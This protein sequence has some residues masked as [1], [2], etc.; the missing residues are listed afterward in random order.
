MAIK[1]KS[2]IM[3]NIRKSYRAVGGK[4]YETWEI[5]FGTDD[6]GKKIR[7][8][9]PS[10]SEARRYVENY[11]RSLD[12]G[13]CVMT[14]LKPR[15]V[16]DA[17]EALD[18][19]AEAG[20]RDV[21]LR[22]CARELIV[23]ETAARKCAASGMTLGP[24]YMEYVK[25]IPE[26][27]EMQR[28]CVRGRIGR[29]ADALGHEYRLA[30]VTAKGVADYVD[31][32]GVA[33][34]TRNNARSYIKTFLS[35]C[36]ADERRYI[37]ENPCAGMKP[38]KEPYKEPVFISAADMEKLAR[39]VEANHPTAIPF[40]VLSYW[41]GIR[42]AEIERLAD[43]PEDIRLEEETIRLSKVKGWTSGR[44]PRI[45]HIEPNALAWMKRHDVRRQLPGRAVVTMR[46]TLYRAAADAG[47]NLGR[48]MGRHSYITH[49]AAKTG[50]AKMVE[51]MAGTSGGMRAKNYDGLST[52]TEG[53]A[54]F[55]IM[56]SPPD[57]ARVRPSL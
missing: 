36:A 15:D 5:Y 39:E 48:N 49:L 44:R 47:V 22:R 13:G 29:W 17:R 56:P 19:L 45:T 32:L 10:L 2:D 41:C 16:L 18:I 43:K 27:C 28:K 20:L 24:A 7:T 3:R 12:T 31:A 30:D 50:D 34:K 14:A 38:E 26:E 35:W 37:A 25:S 57:S 4:A 55:S 53:Q 9:K 52:K 42:T 23:R 21:T 11:F 6:R 33:V 54:Y 51:S 40:M 46:E 1:S 8:V